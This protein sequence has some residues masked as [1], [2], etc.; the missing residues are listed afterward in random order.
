M[1]LISAAD[2]NLLLEY[3][4]DIELRRGATVLIPDN[5]S[6]LDHDPTDNSGGFTGYWFAQLVGPGTVNSLEDGDEIWIDK[7]EETVNVTIRNYLHEKWKPYNAADGNSAQEALAKVYVNSVPDY[8]YALEG[9][10]LGLCSPL[11]LLNFNYLGARKFIPIRLNID[12]TESE[13]GL[14]MIEPRNEVLI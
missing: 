6:I 3:P 9:S 14:T 11:D 2:Y 12:L 4:D 1:A 13:T 5:Y 7:P 8:I 10:A